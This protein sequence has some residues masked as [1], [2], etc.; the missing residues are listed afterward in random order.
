MLRAVS[1]RPTLLCLW[2]DLVWRLLALN[3]AENAA[4]AGHSVL[5]FSMEMSKE[6]LRMLA[7]SAADSW[8]TLKNLNNREDDE[9]FSIDTAQEKLR[10]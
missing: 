9:W 10:A 5:V 1:R 6:Q 2:L 8:S 7:M 3:V 4:M